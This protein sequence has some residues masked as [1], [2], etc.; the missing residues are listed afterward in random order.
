MTR[1]LFALLVLASLVLPVGA[2]AEDTTRWL[3]DASQAPRLERVEQG[4]P[5]VVLANGQV[6]QLDLQ[7]WMKLYG[8]PG[9]SVAVFDDFQV[10]WRKT[11]GVREVGRPDPVTLDTT[12]QAGSVSKPVTALA[13]MRAVEKGR[14]TLDQNVNDELTSWRVPDN[15]FTRDQKVTLRRLLSHSAGLSVHGFPGYAVGAPL[16]TLLQVLN[17]EKPANTAPVR[18]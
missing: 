10:V 12:F 14:V 16:P 13:A 17:G 11:Y 8:V 18:W 5:S 15:D 3:A 1:H 7:G 6:L 2:L 4:L 9:L